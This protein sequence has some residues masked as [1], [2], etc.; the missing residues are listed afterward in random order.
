MAFTIKIRIECGGG[1]SI[2]STVMPYNLKDEATIAG[3][4]GNLH[5]KDVDAHWIQ[6]SLAKFY[7]VWN[8]K[9]N[10]FDFYGNFSRRKG[11]GAGLNI[12]ILKI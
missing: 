5:A 7:K 1:Y 10:L 6:R 11:E 2:L 3:R 8:Y 4:K 12:M 9:C